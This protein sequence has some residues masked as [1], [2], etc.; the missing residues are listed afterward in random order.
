MIVMV[1]GVKYLQLSYGFPLHA[2][3]SMTHE[4]QGIYG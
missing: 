1:N 3:G 2:T 4:C